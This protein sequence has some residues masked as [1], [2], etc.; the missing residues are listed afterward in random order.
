MVLLWLALLG[1]LRV[2]VGSISCDFIIVGPSSF[3]VCQ[4]GLAPYQNRGVLDPSG[5][6][7]RWW[8]GVDC[9]VWARAFSGLSFWK[10]LGFVQARLS[11]PRCGALSALST[12]LAC[13]GSYDPS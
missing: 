12:V 13:K 7:C 10:R 11:P 4:H 1:A 6:N 3:G 8:L 5:S 2:R 9:K